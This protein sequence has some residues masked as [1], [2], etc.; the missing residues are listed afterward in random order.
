MRRSYLYAVM[1]V[2]LLGGAYFAWGAVKGGNAASYRT[3]SAARGDVIQSV[4]ANGTLKPVKV[5]NVGAQISGR[6]SALHA[7]FND[8]VTEGEVLAELDDASLKA[9][10]AQSKAQLESAKAQLA[11]AQVNY[12]RARDLAARGAGAK[13]ALDEAAANLGIAQAAVGSAEAR[14][15]IDQV[16]LDYA[17]IRSPVSGVVMSR[18]VDVGQTVAASLSAPQIFSIAQD[19]SKMQIDTT[20]AEADVGAIKAGMDATFRVDAFP[21]R[22]FVSKVRQVRLNPTT[23]SNVVS[24][25]VVLDVDNADL[26]LLPGMTAYVQIKIADAQDALRVPNAALRYKPASASDATGSGG[27]TGGGGSRAAG[28]GSA[29]TGRTIY[30]LDGGSPKA[31]Q[32]ETGLTDGKVTAIV[33]G[34]LKEGDLVITGAASAEAPAASGGGQRLGGPRMF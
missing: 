28:G 5:V 2:A 3:E 19:L 9:Q 25:N 1:A 32:V 27:G 20:V 33:S 18:D 11:L 8:Q 12:D 6:I 22:S 23:E 24:Y 15:A 34:D 10:L 21:G 14:V 30:V 17:I 4:S 7:D 26:T 13:A 31:I 29:G 16:N